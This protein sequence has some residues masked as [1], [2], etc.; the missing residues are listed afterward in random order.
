MSARTLGRHHVGPAGTRD[1]AGRLQI[2]NP[3]G[4]DY[5]PLR[6]GVRQHLGQTHYAETA[7]HAPVTEQTAHLD[8]DAV[9]ALAEPAPW[10]GPEP[11]GVDESHHRIADATGTDKTRKE[12]S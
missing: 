5:T 7:L 9:L 4:P 1:A 6:A 3:V 11:A 12:P 10:F 8:P 2:A